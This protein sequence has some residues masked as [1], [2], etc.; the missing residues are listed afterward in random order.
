MTNARGTELV[1][2]CRMLEGSVNAAL[3]DA[4]DFA[5]LHLVT[6]GAIDFDAAARAVSDLLLAL[7]QDPTSEL[8]AGTPRRGATASAE[9]LPSAPFALTA[10]ANDGGYDEMVVVRDISFHAVCA[11]HLGPFVGVAH[12]AYIPGERIVGLSKLARVVEHFARR[13]QTQE[14][15]TTQV[16]DALSETLG[17]RGVG[18]V[19]E[20]EHLCI[21]LRGARARGAAVTGLLRDD[22]ATRAEFL[23]LA[24]GPSR[25]TRS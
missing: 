10:F 7:G 17:P 11:H 16:V 5:E 25:P 12:V 21:P 20:A 23:T 8:L 15:L 19:V 3:V 13:L 1:Q 18:V 9:S 4:E 14:T 2:E 24:T 6:L 22:P